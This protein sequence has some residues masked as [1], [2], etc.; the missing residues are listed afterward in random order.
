MRASNVV[1]IGM[2]GSGKSTVGV[3]L[4]KRLGLGFTDTDL[5]IQQQ[6]GRTLQALV[7]GDGYKALRKIEEQVLLKLNVKK[8]VI[9]TGGS[10]VYSAL[11]MAH[12]QQD[13]V[14]V[15]LD[16]SN[17]EVRRRIGDFSLRGISR[18]PEQ[19]LD[20]LFEERFALYTGCADLTIHGDGN[21]PE[22]V[23]D[24][25]VAALVGSDRFGTPV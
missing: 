5:L 23:C 16:I 2:P 6:A 24:D 13:G 18:H 11:A 1:L 20:D 22:Q 14:A 19:S 21:H 9:S 10:A 12:L 7:E 3:L 8:Q 17:A 25:I 4:A 15:F